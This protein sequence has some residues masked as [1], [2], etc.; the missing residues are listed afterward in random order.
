MFRAINN[1]SHLAIPSTGALASFLA[2]AKVAGCVESSIEVDAFKESSNGSCVLGRSGPGRGRGLF[3]SHQVPARE[4]ILVERAA[5]DTFADAGS[6]ASVFEHPGTEPIWGLVTN[7]ILLQKASSDGDFHAKQR[8]KSLETF[9]RHASMSQ[10]EKK[11]YLGL[12]QRLC[13]AVRADF[14]EAV[15]E[16]VIADLLAVV[17]AD[18]HT[19]RGSRSSAV[20]EGVGLFPWLHLANHSCAPNA[21][22]K[23]SLDESSSSG[24]AENVPVFSD[25]TPTCDYNVC[26]RKVKSPKASRQSPAVMKLYT[27]KPMEANEEVCISYV[28]GRVLL[29]PV[30]SRRE[31]LRRGFGF[32]CLCERCLSEE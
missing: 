3:T 6:I 30:A 18:A 11:V 22:F 19:V 16:Q 31:V 10:K 8:L 20:G 4:Q 28:D 25:S 26:V 14:A 29:M 23:A 2:L 9:Y 17:K 21:F 1:L 5:L 12:A 7:F 27:F 13:S 32:H 24:E 15:N